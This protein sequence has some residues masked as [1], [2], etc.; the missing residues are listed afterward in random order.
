LIDPLLRRNTSVNYVL[1]FCGTQADQDAFNALSPE[2][3]GARYTQ[4][5][6][7]F[8]ENGPKIRGSNQLQPPETATT[9]RLGGV[10]PLISDGPFIEGNELIGG[11]AEIEVAD[12]DEALAMAKSWPGG[13][14]VEIRSVFD[15]RSRP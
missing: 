5:G 7:W 9:V 14:A 6:E 4:V 3:L 2:E 11:Y 13:G 1:L 8:A 12:L 15:A 10:E